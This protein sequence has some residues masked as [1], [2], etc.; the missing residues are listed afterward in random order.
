MCDIKL[1]ILRPYDSEYSCTI[2][3]DGDVL[4]P[5]TAETFTLSQVKKMWKEKLNSSEAKGL[6]SEERNAIFQEALDYS[7]LLERLGA[8]PKSASLTVYTFDYDPRLFP[9]ALYEDDLADLDFYLEDSERAERVV[10]VESIFDFDDELTI[11]L[12]KG[13][14]PN[15]KRLESTMVCVSQH[16]PKSIHLWDPLVYDEPVEYHG[17]VHIALP[18]RAYIKPPF[19]NVPN[20]VYVHYPSSGCVMLKDLIPNVNYDTVRKVSLVC[21]HDSMLGLAVAELMQMPNLHEVSM[22]PHTIDQLFVQGIRLA[23]VKRL[24]IPEEVDVVKGIDWHRAK[25]LFPNLTEFSFNGRTYIN[26]DESIA[27][28]ELSNPHSPLFP[29]GVKTFHVSKVKTLYQ[30]NTAGEDLFIP[31]LTLV[32]SDRSGRTITCGLHLSQRFQSPPADLLPVARFEVLSEESDS[33]EVEST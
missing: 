20:V 30:I 13:L 4:T 32:P 7:T 21:R 9:I 25:S 11:S 8:L 10:Y 1:A 26:L 23:Q 17:E 14:F 3:V 24:T 19:A 33:E 27:H 6:T 18:R 29:E 28:L 5:R 31:Q 16:S 12:E 22:Y 15:L 2:Q